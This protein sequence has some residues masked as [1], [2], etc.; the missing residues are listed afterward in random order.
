ML[1]FHWNDARTQ[2]RRVVVCKSKAE[3]MRL[4]DLSRSHLAWA[5][6]IKWK[7]NYPPFSEGAQAAWADPGT[8]YEKT[9]EGWQ[10]V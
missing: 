5:S 7:Q 3:Y 2:R 4:T 8:V 6:I 10:P 1:I 9:S